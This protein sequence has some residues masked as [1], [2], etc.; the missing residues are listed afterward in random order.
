MANRRVGSFVFCR[1]LGLKNTEVPCLCLSVVKAFSIPST[2]SY[3][4]GRAQRAHLSSHASMTLPDCSTDIL[5]SMSRADC[6]CGALNLQNK[7]I[8]RCFDCN[9]FGHWAGEPICSA[10]DQTRDQHNHKK[11]EGQAHTT[12]KLPS[13]SSV[14]ACPESFV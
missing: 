9:R 1:W 3:G 6:H 8:T 13:K 10:R 14:H 11:P 2:F 7:L 12:I 4:F 5:R